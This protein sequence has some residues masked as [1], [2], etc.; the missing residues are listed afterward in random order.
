MTD[1]RTSPPSLGELNPLL[2][3]EIIARAL[4]ED[5]GSGDITSSAIVPENRLGRGVIVAKAPG[6]IAGLSLVREV[7]R[8]IDSGV[9]VTVL[10]GEGSRV[11]R[12]QQ[13]AEL[14]GPA[15]ALLTGERL[16]LNFL[17]HLS[18]IATATRKMVDLCA[19]TRARIVDTRKTLPGLRALQKYAVRVGGGS[20]HR[21]GLFDA[22][23]IKDNHIA[24]AG[25]VAGA[26]EMARVR[27]GHTQRIEV[28]VDSLEQLE[29]ALAAGAELI[30]L[31]N[32]N[33][34]TL[35]RAV[36]L[37]AGRA[38]LEASGGITLDS[39]AAVAAAGV[40]LISVGALTHSVAA[41]D[42]SLEITV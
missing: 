9:E 1:Y 12:G 30:L 28:E 21:F 35:R 39:V 42:L 13:L 26:V 29:E 33:L 25:G 10:T 3:D 2:L 34:D 16:V 19:G 14:K 32:M 7:Y 24:L 5:V 31:D 37:T 4:I 22:V 11:N 27:A 18:G 23:L 40:D 8:R 41:L 6:V 38:L 20:N 17:Q 36:A 15:R